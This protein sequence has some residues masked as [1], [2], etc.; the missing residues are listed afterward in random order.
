MTV[1]FNL[2][3]IKPGQ[4]TIG[5]YIHIIATGKNNHSP[6]EWTYPKEKIQNGVPVNY[7]RGQPFLIQR[8]KPYRQRFNADSN[9]QLPTAIKILVY[10]QSGMLILEKGFEVTNAS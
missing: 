1:R 3:N 4:N 10:D 9:S 5:G 2:A 6:S 7:R 8:F